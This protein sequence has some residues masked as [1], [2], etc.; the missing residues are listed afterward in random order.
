MTH[1]FWDSAYW[2]PFLDSEGVT[3]LDASFCALLIYLILPETKLQQ[4][5]KNLLTTRQSLYVCV[6]K[7]VYIYICMYLYMYLYLHT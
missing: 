2:G 6:Y 3:F 1:T 5:Q 4:A 7:Y